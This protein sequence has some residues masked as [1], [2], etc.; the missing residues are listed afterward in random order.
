MALFRT[1]RGLLA[2][3]AIAAGV[4]TS[5]CTLMYTAPVKP[6]LGLIATSIKAPLTPDFRGN[7]VGVGMKKFSQRHTGYFHEFL[8]T[9]IDLAWGEA[10]LRKIARA[11][12]I[13]KVSYAD[14]EFFH[15]FGIYSSFTI[16]VYGE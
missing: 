2:A 10:D 5:G 3:A 16:N 1:A 11:G 15:L 9:Q 6:P 13:E 7:P 12:G 8:L 14:Y 4:A